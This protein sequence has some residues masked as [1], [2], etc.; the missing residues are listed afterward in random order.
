MLHDL[1]E[2]FEG[3]NKHMVKGDAFNIDYVDFLKAFD[4]VPHQS[5]LK[6]GRFCMDR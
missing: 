6:E 3:V 4:E 2:F 1:L 5:L